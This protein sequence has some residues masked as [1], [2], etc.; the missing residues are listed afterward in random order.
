MPAIDRTYAHDPDGK[1][2]LCASMCS[3]CIFEVPGR[4]LPLRPGRLRDLIANA[5]RRESYVVCHATFASPAV[6]RGF[7]D[8][9]STNQLRIFGRLGAIVEIAPPSIEGRHR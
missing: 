7:F 5:R 8:R 4:R 6:C 9:F 1:L 3:T 2:R